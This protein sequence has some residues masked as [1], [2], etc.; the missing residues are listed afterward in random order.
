[1]SRSQRTVTGFAVQRRTIGAL[2]LR[3]VNARY[4]RENIGVLWMIGEPMMLATVI[5]LLHL[6]QPTHYGSDI[7]PAP[8]A[9]IG[10]VV[11]IIFRGLFNRAEGA[12]EQNQSLL[13]HRQ[14]TVFD[15]M[16]A[17]ALP[18]IV[19]C[20]SAMVALLGI[21][22]AVGYAQWPARPLQLMGAVSLMV[23][24]SFALS[25][26]AASVTY[27]NE[28][29]GRQLHVLSYFSIPIS[30]AF[31]QLEWTP[32]F[33]RNILSWFPMALIM[34]Q[35]RYGQFRSASD[36][37][38]APAYVAAWGAVLTY[39]GLILVRRVRDRIHG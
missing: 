15:I 37:Y 10:Y 20:L 16:V 34:E 9:I 29:V 28:T 14:V 5:T 30:A 12:I 39:V 4:G 25:L 1:M 21:A 11:F 33:F 22:I 18:E 2:V 35:A 31:F 17:R 8:F 19:G 13:Y 32:L 23:W 7:Q 24:W 38:T 26:I 3:E 6:N 27:R 36:T